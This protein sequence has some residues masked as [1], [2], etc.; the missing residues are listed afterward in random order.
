MHTY[1][2]SVD[3]PSSSMSATS[4]FSWGGYQ[5]L[6]KLL[7]YVF[8]GHHYFELT[9]EGNGCKFTNREHF[10][11]LA[12]WIGRVT[13]GGWYRDLMANTRRGFES[14]NRALK[15]RVEQQQRAPLAAAPRTAA[16]SID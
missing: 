11:G 4:G 1:L 13:G 7:T 6:G 8:Y 15:E 14:M 12:V 2:Q 5:G 10:Y 9:A 16:R 3:P